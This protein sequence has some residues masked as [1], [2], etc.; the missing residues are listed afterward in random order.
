MLGIALNHDGA[1]TKNEKEKT[2]GIKFEG[3][4]GGE[5]GGGGGGSGGGKDSE[6]GEGSGGGK[7]GEDGE[8]GGGDGGGED[9]E[10]DDT[11]DSEFGPSWEPGSRGKKRS[12]SPMDEGKQEKL[13][14]ILRE[15]CQEAIPDLRKY[16]LGDLNSAT[17][18]ESLNS[19]MQ[20]AISDGLDWPSSSTAKFRIPYKKFKDVVDPLVLKPLQNPGS[21]SHEKEYAEKIGQSRIKLHH[22][23]LHHNLQIGWLEGLLGTESRAKTILRNELYSSQNTDVTTYWPYSF[24]RTANFDVIYEKQIK[25]SKDRKRSSF[26]VQVFDPNSEKFRIET[27]ANIGNDNLQKWR[28]LPNAYKFDAGNR[29]FAGGKGSIDYVYFYTMKQPKT[30]RPDSKASANT[31]VCVKPKDSIFPRFLPRSQVNRYLNDGESIEMIIEAL[32]D[33]DD[34]KTPWEFRAQKMVCDL[35]GDAGQW[36]PTTTLE[37]EYWRVQAAGRA[38]PLRGASPYSRASAP[39]QNT[40]QAK[41]SPPRASPFSQGSYSWKPFVKEE[42]PFVEEQGEI[43]R[44]REEID[45][46]KKRLEKI[47]DNL[48]TPEYL[49]SALNKQFEQLKQLIKGAGASGGD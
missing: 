11:T 33:R 9:I 4:E 1:E 2:G 24:L 22:I 44:Q 3:D 25:I 14:E 6:D 19:R 48:V 21:E 38:A 36:R 16:L 45:D 7:G 46:I 13:Q 47:E 27:R 49:Q 23:C 29:N 39:Q 17:S 28:L 37:E 26:G 35:T 31:E 41:W 5:D 30:G 18:L 42:M 15:H 20:R 40:A 12:A 8:G 10:G 34:M 43:R 32:A